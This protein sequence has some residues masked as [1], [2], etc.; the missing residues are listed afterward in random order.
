MKSV[1]NRRTAI[2]ALGAIVAVSCASAATLLAA[3]YGTT[4]HAGN[5]VIH[6]E[7]AISPSALP[8]N[9]MTPISFHANASVTTADG[10]HVPP[11]QTIHLQVDKHVRI[12]A[13]G[14]PTC[15][16][17]EIEATTPAQAMKACGPAL[18]GKGSA[19]AQVEF[20][21]QAPFSAK[22]PLLAFNGPASGGGYG[23]QQYHEQLYYIYVSVPAPTAVVVVAKLSKDTGKYGYRIFV[24]VPRIAGGSGSVTNVE[25]EI[26][27]QWTYK[28]RQHSYLNAECPHGYFFNQVEV[29][30]GDG[31]NLS[32]SII[33]RCQSKG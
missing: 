21:E 1:R 27:R 18:I 3:N 5:L 8:K 9:K 2:V 22:G 28:G 26:N 31:T 7:G 6:F 16:P 4:I 29:A 14:L 24:T 32:G 10:S 30:Y 11:A 15:S 23:G 20:P 12:D 33:N 19:A 25:F 17:G 13:T